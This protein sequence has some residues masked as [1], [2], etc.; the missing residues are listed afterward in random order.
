MV[1]PRGKSASSSPMR[2][3]TQPDHDIGEADR[4]PPRIRRAP[5]QDDDLEEEHEGNQR[6]DVADRVEADGGQDGEQIDH[7]APQVTMP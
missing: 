1:L 7:A 5:A 3:S 6:R 4:H 2:K